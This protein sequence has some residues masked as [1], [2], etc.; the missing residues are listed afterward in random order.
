MIKRIVLTGGPGSGKTTVIE[1]IKKNYEEM[2]YKVII[3]DET[4]T[5]LINMGIRPFGE[6]AIDMVDFQELVLKE[7]LEKE[8]LVDKSLEYM[9]NDKIIIVYDR[10]ALDNRAYVNNEE[11]ENVLSRFDNITIST[12]MEKYDL[13]IDLVS[14]ED[15][16]TLENNTA[17]TEDV[18]TALELGNKTLK[19]WLGHENIK[20]VLPKDDI[21]DKINEVL[22]IINLNLNE[23]QIKRQE[24]YLI[25]ITNTKLNDEI[26]HKE[27]IQTY[28]ESSP[29]VE[30]RLRKISF[31]GVVS[32]VFTTY[33]INDDGRKELVSEECITEKMYNKLLEFADFK[34]KTINKKRY[35]F[36]NDGTYYYIDKFDFVDNVGILEVNI[37][38]DEKLQ[39]PDNIVVLDKVTN[40]LEYHN[41][42][43]ARKKDKKLV[44][45]K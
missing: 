19:S 15:F 25:D 45:K 20:I 27:I 16:Y 10:G 13:V 1:R 11:F 6:N 22:N 24:K 35:Y 4:A 31:N 21:E 17:R 23:K 12:L 34:K 33:Y 7:Q 26:P 29:N 14:R 41:S 44:M 37:I 39:F 43:I 40:D 28:L 32:Y 30:K 38:K 5:H 9:N 42:Y 3:V 8:K 18:T 2:G 36:T